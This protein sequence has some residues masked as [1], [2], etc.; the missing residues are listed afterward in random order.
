AAAGP[1]ARDAVALVAAKLAVSA[2]VLTHGFSHVSDDDYARTVIA[3]QFAH[4]PRL[5][6]SGTSWLPFPF[7]VTGAAMAVM[8]RSLLLARATA[9]ALSAAAVAAPYAAFRIVRMGRGASIAATFIAMALPWNAWLGAAT[10]PEGWVGALVAAALV[11]MTIEEARPLCAAALLAASLSRYDAWPACLF[12]ACGCVARLRRGAP[13]RRELSWIAVAL[14]GIAA[15]MLWNALVHGSPVHFLARVRNFRHAIGAADVPL[16]DKLLGYPRSLVTETPEAAGFG[17]LGLAATIRDPSLRARWKWPLAAAAVTLAVLVTGDV[18]DGAPTHH[19]G[20]A[21]GPL[22]WLLVGCGVDAIASGLQRVD[23][24]RRRPVLA[25]GAIAGLAWLALLP[26][27]WADAPG[28]TDYERRDPQIARGE[29][30][31]R[32]DVAAAEITPCSFEHFALLAAW[33]RPERATVHDRTGAAP[34]PACPTVVE[35]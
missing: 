13:A 29:D 22:W 34:T 23:P 26:G 35:R 18:R 7:W 3:Q 11:A 21:L 25:A 27:R 19:A 6:P 33:G 12:F 30:L 31:A 5:D 2:W 8:G 1:I 16:S 28:R 4:A 10:V 17:L 32:R 24:A 14:G 9:V 15:W 20:R